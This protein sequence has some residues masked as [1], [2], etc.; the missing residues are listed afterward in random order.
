MYKNHLCMTVIYVFKILCCCCCRRCVIP[1]CGIGKAESHFHDVSRPSKDL[2]CL[3]PWSKVI[4]FFH[5]IQWFL[6]PWFAGEEGRR[7]TCSKLGW[8][9]QIFSDSIVPCWNK[10]VELFARLPPW[11]VPF[12]VDGTAPEITWRFQAHHRSM[13]SNKSRITYLWDQYRVRGF[14]AFGPR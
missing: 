8:C 2:I 14:I 6:L 4:C 11:C 7:N 3:Q 12:S 5:A 13:F 9:F 10:Q 1:C